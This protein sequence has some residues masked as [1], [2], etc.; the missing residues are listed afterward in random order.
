MFRVNT[1]FSLI[2]TR[3][4]DVFARSN[5]FKEKITWKEEAKA[6]ELRCMNLLQKELVALQEEVKVGISLQETEKTHGSPSTMASR[7]TKLK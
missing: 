3:R 2:S 4:G 5:P 7:V 6:M 1:I